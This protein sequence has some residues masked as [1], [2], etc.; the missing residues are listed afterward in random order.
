MTA[1][2]LEITRNQQAFP[3]EIALN[4]LSSITLQQARRNVIH[5]DDSSTSE[6]IIEKT[7]KEST[8]QFIQNLEKIS[9]MDIKDKTSVHF[10]EPGTQPLQP[11]E[12]PVD[13]PSSKVSED[14]MGSAKMEEWKFTPQEA[15]AVS[16][17][18]EEC[19][20]KLTTIGFMIPAH[21][22]P[23]WDDTIKTIDETYGVPDEPGM[24]FR[25]D[26][27]LLPLVSTK[28]EKMQRDRNYVCEVLKKVLHEVKNY[29]R[30]DSLK[31]EVDKIVRKREGE[32]VLEEKA[33][34]WLSQAERFREL[35]E[36][37]KKANEEDTKRTTKLAQESDA[38]VDHALLLSSGKL[39]YAE[40]WAKARLEQ[41]EVK[42]QL[43]K[44]DILNKLSE[45]SKEYNA[46]Q[47]ISAE[48]NAHL[49]ADIKEKEEQIDMWT[50]KYNE[51]LVERQQE[52]DELK[53]L[54]EEQKLEMEKMHASMD[55]RQKF[56]E[57]CIAEEER[58]K[59]EEKLN[60]AATVIQSTWRGHMVRQQLGQYKDLWKRLK[61]R[62]KLR[63]K[64]GPTKKKKRLRRK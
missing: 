62:N 57:E 4:R 22:D 6:R 28:T 33:Q 45:Y 7:L 55:E 47:I 14:D 2:E 38:Q 61:K 12:S 3:K 8:D 46:E 13:T 52:I 41:Q 51:D 24:I 31:E 9:K 59:E 53:R 40:R 32:R 16:S 23:R 58:L 11:P 27:D 19:L 5:V 20:A 60:K 17:M 64:K 37:D 42:L 34:T 1:S 63:K 25:E 50:K 26:M 36:S 48:M 35:L 39:G 54:I 44:K 21:V 18:L 43:Q 56:I 10:T 15:A 49:E 29:G 30:F